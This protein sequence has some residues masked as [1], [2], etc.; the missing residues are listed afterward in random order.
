MEEPKDHDHVWVDTINSLA[1]ICQKC[2]WLKN[3]ITGEVEPPREE[4]TNPPAIKDE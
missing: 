2:Q 3:P 4:I 1:Q